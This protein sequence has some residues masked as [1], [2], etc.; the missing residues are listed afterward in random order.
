MTLG[1]PM[2]IFDFPIEPLGPVKKMDMGT[3]AFTTKDVDS[4]KM[5]EVPGR[6]SY[7]IAEE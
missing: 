2:D 5:T 1:L 4:T 3:C 6:P 7:A